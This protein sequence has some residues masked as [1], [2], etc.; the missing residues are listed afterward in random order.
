[1]SD[2]A[3]EPANPPM[4]IA[5][6]SLPTADDD[7]L[8]KLANKTIAN[9]NKSVMTFAKNLVTVCFSAIGVIVALQQYTSAHTT[10][11]NLVALGFAI[12]LLLAA[13]VVSSLAVA[14][15]GLRVSENDYSEISNELHRAAR[16]RYRL[17]RVALALI[18]L[19]IALATWV[20]L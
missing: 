8:R 18:V 2:D 3:A 5:E 14:P 15:V 9:E 6:G 20:I 4:I 13:G 11:H 7:R 19:A 12:G 10:R 17:T 1:M 16:Y